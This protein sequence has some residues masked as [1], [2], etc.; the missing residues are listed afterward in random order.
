MQVVLEE[1]ENGQARQVPLR[2]VGIGSQACLVACDS[3]GNVFELHPDGNR[4][5]N[6]A[7]L[8]LCRQSCCLPA[9]PPAALTQADRIWLQPGLLQG[10][11]QAKAACLMNC[12]PVLISASGQTLFCTPHENRATVLPDRDKGPVL[13]VY[14]CKVLE[15]SPSPCLQLSAYMRISV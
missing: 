8:F 6:R 9:Y 15:C 13:T 3:Q 12:M 5:A 4:C 11:R 10:P 1:Q 2:I 14:N 7:N